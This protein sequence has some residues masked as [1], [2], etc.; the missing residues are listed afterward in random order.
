[1]QDPKLEQLVPPDL[2]KYWS[3]RVT[4]RLGRA[5]SHFAQ[6]VS[7][8]RNWVPKKFLEVEPEGSDVIEVEDDENDGSTRAEQDSKQLVL[9]EK[10]EQNETASF[11]NGLLKR[12]KSS[13]DLENK[14]VFA[15]RYDFFE[16]ARRQLELGLCDDDTDDEEK[17]QLDH[18]TVG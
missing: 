13:E 5:T 9:V 4:L 18:T 2:E 7:H 14:Q 16:L 6:A 17:V 3:V 8:E 11:E 15:K 12:A 10:A 1:M